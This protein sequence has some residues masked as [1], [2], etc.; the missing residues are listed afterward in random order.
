MDP[1]LAL[2][3]LE[4]PGV[5]ERTLSRIMTAMRDQRA[6]ANPAELLRRDLGLGERSRAALHAEIRGGLHRTRTLADRLASEGVQMRLRG[7]P[8]YPSRIE[9]L[10]AAPPPV[11]FVHGDDAL[12]SAPTIALLSSREITSHLVAATVLATRCA[13]EEGLSIVVGG[14]KSTHRIA[15]SIARAARGRRAVVLD[16]GIL[17]GFSGNLRRD[18]FGLGPARLSFD[19]STTLALSRF[20]PRDHAAPANGRKRDELISALGDILFI[21]SARPGGETERLCTRAIDRGRCVLLWHGENPGLVEA[22][23]QP[24]DENE[25]RQ[26]FRR[27]L[28]SPRV[29]ARPSPAG[30]RGPER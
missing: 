28:D 3:L 10:C 7:S 24:V 20:R 2:L 1:F 5:G 12:L 13:V 14:M 16:R 26:G 21:A 30:R 9:H 17:A 4:L 27:F 11:L 15:S 22:G 19:G 18:P 23:A 8:G 25:L 6:P 29:S